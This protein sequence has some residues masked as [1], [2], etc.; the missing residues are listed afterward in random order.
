[1]FATSVSANI[2]NVP[3]LNGSNFKDWIDNIMIILGCMDLNY[4]LQVEQP[5]SLTAESFLD[6]KKNFEKWERSNRVSLMIIKRN[7]PEAFR[8]TASKEITMASEYLAHIEQRFV[9]NEK[10]ETSTLLVNLISIKCKGKGNIREYIRQMSHYASKLSALKLEVFE[11]LLVHLVLLSLPAQY[12][13]FKVSYNCQREKL[14][15]NELISYC[16]QEE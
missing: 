7:I 11:D 13:H 9:K 3:M 16:V 8:G 10:A 1:M 5:A 14:T 4:T 15:L 2:N 12:S 6:D